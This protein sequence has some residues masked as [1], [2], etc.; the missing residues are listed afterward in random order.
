MNIPYIMW[1]NFSKQGKKGFISFCGWV[2]F[3][4]GL[5]TYPLFEG[6]S[7]SSFG[8]TQPSLFFR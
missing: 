6:S 1:K 2:Q 5:P 3:K 8:E 4:V 7:L